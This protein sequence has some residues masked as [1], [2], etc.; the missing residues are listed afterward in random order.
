MQ[1]VGEEKCEIHYPLD[2]AFDLVGLLRT[3]VIKPRFK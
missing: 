3:S 1:M 2:S